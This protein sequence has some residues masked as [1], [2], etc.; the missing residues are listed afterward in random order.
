M[1]YDDFFN[2]K[3]QF[4]KHTNTA[5][6]NI[7]VQ[8]LSGNLKLS[9]LPLN[10]MANRQIVANVVGHYAKE[11]GL[12]GTVGVANHPER[13]SSEVPAFTK[14]LG[15]EVYVNAKAGGINPALDNADNMKSTLVHEKGHFD[16]NIKGVSAGLEEH[17]SIYL[18]QMQDKSFGAATAD[19]QKGIVASFGQYLMN[20]IVESDGN[21]INYA[22]KMISIFNKT[23]AAGIVMRGDF[24]SG[25][26]S[27]NS[28][29]FNKKGSSNTSKVEYKKLKELKD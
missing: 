22:S 14:L 24:S 28:V 9:H 29:S 26:G 20:N 25:D 21:P 17:A 19:F 18:Q 23:N 8:A 7:Y 10:N 15:N 1:Y 6:N 16:D 12:T 27:S 2:S 13:P 4:L 11:V 5:T 3:G